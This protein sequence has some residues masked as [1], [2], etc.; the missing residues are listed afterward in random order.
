MNGTVDKLLKALR[1]IEQVS[2]AIYDQN[3]PEFEDMD[4]ALRE[5]RDAARN[6]L[7]GMEDA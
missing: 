5:V 7:D 3:Q 2:G 4:E 1:H 6:A